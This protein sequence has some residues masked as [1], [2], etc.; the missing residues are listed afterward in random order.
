MSETAENH[1]PSESSEFCNDD[2][3]ILRLEQG[4]YLV[5][6]TSELRNRIEKHFTDGEKWTKKFRPVAIHRILMRCQEDDDLKY[7][8]LCMEKF[9]VDN[10]RG[11]Q[12]ASDSLSKKDREKAARLIRARKGTCLHCEDTGHYTFECPKKQQLAGKK[13]E[14]REEYFDKEA[15]SNEEMMSPL[16]NP[17]QKSARKL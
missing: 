10:V 11:A 9:A 13:H 7:T 6:Q 14:R 17:P 3:F 2:L 16:L 12:F 1:Q 8:I 15:D 5:E 4:K